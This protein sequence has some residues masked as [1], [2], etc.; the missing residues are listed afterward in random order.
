[1]GFQQMWSFIY[2]I[3]ILLAPVDMKKLFFQT[4]YDDLLTHQCLEAPVYTANKQTKRE[5][6]EAGCEKSKHFLHGS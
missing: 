3:Y 5:E 6:V 2:I 4:L 1:M